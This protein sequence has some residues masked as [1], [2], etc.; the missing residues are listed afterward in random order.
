MPLAVTHSAL[1]DIGRRRSHN[2]DRCC[3]DTTLG[4]FLVCDG[5]GGSKAGEI[6][7][8]LAV[9]TIHRHINEASQNAAFPMIGQSDPT[10]SP[11]GNR[12]LSAICDANRVIHR[13]GH[14]N[15]DWAGMGTTVVA[16]LLTNRLMS[17]AHV[18]DSRLYLVRAR[19]IQPLTT[20]H[21][22]VA[23]QV[24]AG[25]MTEAEAEQSPRRNLVTRALGVAPEVDITIGEAELQE[26]D[27]L[28]L[29]SDG[30]TKGVE[31]AR[32]LNVL[33]HTDDMI[34][35]TRRL[36]AL[37]NEA[38]GDDNTTVITIAVHEAT[39]QPM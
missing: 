16:V 12:L 39:E 30:L 2:E 17:F 33:T 34:G 19:A 10:I 35:A 14:K 8:G 25:L 32:L 27:R 22:W 31:T 18:G 3:T 1:S 20:D 24:R 7:S 13:E 5:M 38:G 37:A 4:L 28:L 11:S 26:G 15:P 36:V 9:E 29:C 21:S 23:E 6:A